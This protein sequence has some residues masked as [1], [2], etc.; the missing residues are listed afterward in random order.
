M[1]LLA[2]HIYHLDDGDETDKIIELL[3]SS[4]VGSGWT[5]E[6]PSED[7]NAIFVPIEID[8]GTMESFEIRQRKIIKSLSLLTELNK[9]GINRIKGFN[10]NVAMRIHTSEFYLPLPGEFV[11]ACGQLGLEICI[12]NTRD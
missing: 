12:F 8:I 3:K 4:G 9:D 2:L 6:R 7:T 5:I 11:T 1:E 10:L